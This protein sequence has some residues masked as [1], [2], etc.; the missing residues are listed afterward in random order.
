MGNNV[1]P[2]I[3][4]LFAA[5][6]HAEGFWVPGS[7]PRRN[8]NPGDLIGKDGVNTPYPD[9]LA[10]AAALHSQLALMLAG[11]SHVYSLQMT[12]RHVSLLW[13]GGDNAAGWCMAVCE[14]LGVDPDSTIADFVRAVRAPAPAAPEATA[15][16]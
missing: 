2:Q 8:H 7:R 10:G 4:I 3:A 14:D 13:T 1:M 6:A 12:W 5:I 9:I 11:S 16:A 15:A